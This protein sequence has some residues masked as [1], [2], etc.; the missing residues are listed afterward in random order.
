[1]IPVEL[2]AV[3]AGSD[4]ETSPDGCGAA[5]TWNRAYEYRRLRD[6][7]QVLQISS[8]GPSSDSLK[9]STNL[10]FNWPPSISPTIVEI[11]DP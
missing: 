10:P 5:A 7:R 2:R 9:A 3:E 4:A 8:L 6:S 11:P 1:M